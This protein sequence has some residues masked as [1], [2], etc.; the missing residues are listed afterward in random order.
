MK[1]PSRLQREIERRNGEGE[2]ERREQ[3]AREKGN[4][5]VA[6]E[7]YWRVNNN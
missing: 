4:T 7:N 3:G 2:H 5:H 1:L 6:W